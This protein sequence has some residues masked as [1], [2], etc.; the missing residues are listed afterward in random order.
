MV[1]DS[2]IKLVLFILIGMIIIIGLIV[3]FLYFWCRKSEEE[4]EE[5]KKINKIKIPQT[6]YIND[7]KS[8]TTRSENTIGIKSNRIIQFDQT[9]SRTRKPLNNFNVSSIIK[10]EIIKQE[11]NNIDDDIT[12]NNSKDISYYETNEYENTDLENKIKLE[13]GKYIRKNNDLDINTN[14]DE[15]EKGEIEKNIKKNNNLDI[16]I[17]NE[18]KEKTL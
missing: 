9:L 11:K 17:N 16:N 7:N 1:I 2:T 15:R 10:K 3:L 12:S 14:N 6:S 5:V 4:I 8:I 18:E 13:M